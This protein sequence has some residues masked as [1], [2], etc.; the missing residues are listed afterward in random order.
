MAGTCYRHK[1]TTVTLTTRHIHTAHKQ[2][3]I[4]F[5][6]IIIIITFLEI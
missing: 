1:S 5:L 4:P 3:Q 2:S 6:I